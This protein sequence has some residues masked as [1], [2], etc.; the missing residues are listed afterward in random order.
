MLFP[1]WDDEHKQDPEM[2]QLNMYRLTHNPI[3]AAGGG[4]TAATN[5]SYLFLLHI[6]KYMYYAC[7]HMRERG[8]ALTNP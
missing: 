8:K 6:Y 5:K 1:Q 2:E 7:I 4:A 3:A